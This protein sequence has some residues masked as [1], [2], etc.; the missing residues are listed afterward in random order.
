MRATVMAIH[1]DVAHRP[2]FPGLN[3]APDL[4]DRLFGDFHVQPLSQKYSCSLLTQ[5]T[6]ISA[7]IPR[8]KEGRIAIVTDVRHG[9]RWTRQRRRAI[10]I[11]G[12][13]QLVSGSQARGRTALSRTAKPCGPGTRCWCQVRG[14]EVGP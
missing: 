1:L 3:R 5:I 13:V 14:G 6:S 11:A 12:R 4:P 8:S 7:A 10:A 9:M 2:Q